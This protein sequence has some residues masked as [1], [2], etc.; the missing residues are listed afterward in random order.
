MK[1][2]TVSPASMEAP[3]KGRSVCTGG[4]GPSTRLHGIAGP[5]G[6]EGAIRDEIQARLPIR[7]SKPH[8]G[9]SGR[10]T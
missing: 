7:C 1:K 8:I 3:P 6:Y 5:G 10:P 2:V 9:L 4:T